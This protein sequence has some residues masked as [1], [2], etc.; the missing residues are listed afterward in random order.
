MIGR[1][2]CRGHAHSLRVSD[3]GRPTQLLPSAARVVGS[4]YGG[5]GGRSY[6]PRCGGIREGAAARGLRGRNAGVGTVLCQRSREWG[7]RVR[8]RQHPFR[9]GS[10]PLAGESLRVR[11]ERF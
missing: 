8:L 4:E 9:L 11:A 3:W 10:G 7:F 6:R 5:P 2:R 1:D